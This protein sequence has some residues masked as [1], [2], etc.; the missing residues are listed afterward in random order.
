MT[1]KQK[2]RFLKASL[3]VARSLEEARQLYDFFLKDEEA[4]LCP[5]VSIPTDEKPVQW[6]LTTASTGK[7]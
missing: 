7:W 3:A 2:L 4:V 6:K 1:D 5:Y